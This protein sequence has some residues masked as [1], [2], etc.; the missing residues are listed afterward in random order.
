M[1][2]LDYLPQYPNILDKCM[3]TTS[4][5]RIPLSRIYYN[6]EEAAQ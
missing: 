4:T 2:P 1:L 3:P 5:A 6:K